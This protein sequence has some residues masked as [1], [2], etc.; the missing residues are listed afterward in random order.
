MCFL[1]LGRETQTNRVLDVRFE[2]AGWSLTWNDAVGID[3][4]KE[5]EHVNYI[6]LA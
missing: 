4:R 2:G 1:Y 6:S 3:L 5:I